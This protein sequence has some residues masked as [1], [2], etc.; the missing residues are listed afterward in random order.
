MFRRRFSPWR[1]RTSFRSGFRPFGR[2][3]GFRRRP[4]FARKKY[5]LINL[6]DTVSTGSG[7]QGCPWQTAQP[8]G[9]TTG[10]C[11]VASTEVPGCCNTI[12]TFELVSQ[13]T[14][15]SFF[16]DNVTIVR[17]FG[18]MYYQDLVSLPVGA[19]RCSANQNTQLDPEQYALRY[20]LMLEW[21]LRKD[22]AADDPGDVDTISPGDIFDR[23]ETFW[24]WKRSRLWQPRLWRSFGTVED[25]MPLGVCSNTHQDSYIV[26]AEASGSQPTFTVPAE[27]TQC[28][29][30]NFPTQEVCPRTHQQHYQEPPLMH[31]TM[32]LRRHIKLR[33]DD[34]LHLQCQVKHPARPGF[35][36]G[37]NC[38]HN[39]L[40]EGW[41]S[42]VKARVTALVQLN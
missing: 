35:T 5:D 20:A 19:Q 36:E 41:T 12:I 22:S 8:C 26:P 31:F 29:I 1:R 37:W 34:R 16:Q 18:D 15:Q 11:D 27:S 10:E 42:N 4:G 14:L 6:F 38:N 33:R 28:T 23:T 32:N 13:A 2:S 17:L 7:Q 30:Q 9:F 3:G 25:G 40:N 24:Y 21:G 39:F